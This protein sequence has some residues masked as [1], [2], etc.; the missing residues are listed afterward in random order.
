MVTTFSTV[1]LC[2]S[3]IKSDVKYATHRSD[4]L[5]VSGNPIPHSEA[6]IKYIAAQTELHHQPTPI[7]KL[8][9]PLGRRDQPLPTDLQMSALPHRWRR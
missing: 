3:V 7:V 8:Q 9:V 1:N 2:M 4:V 5:Q 6:N